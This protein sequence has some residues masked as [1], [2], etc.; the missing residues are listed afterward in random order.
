M[1][2][3]KA[4]PSELPTTTILRAFCSFQLNLKKTLAPESLSGVPDDELD[5]F[6]IVLPEIASKDAIRETTALSQGMNS[7]LTAADD[8]LITKYDAALIVESQIASVMGHEFGEEQR[9]LVERL[10]EEANQEPEEEEPA[11]PPQ[12]G[13]PDPDDKEDE[14]E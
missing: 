10:K 3:V 13:E 5:A 6:E 1:A 2:A 7:V 9:T 8:G 11:F 4:R 12:F 14:E